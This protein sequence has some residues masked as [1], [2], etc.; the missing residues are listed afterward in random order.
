ME[1]VV[2]LF[3]TF[4]AVFC[5]I[6]FLIY[7]YKWTVGSADISTCVLFFIALYASTLTLSWFT[8]ETKE[9]QKQYYKLEY[10]YTFENNEY[11]K[12]S[13]YVKINIED[14]DISK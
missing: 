7:F 13:T 12:D 3:S 1:T 5:V 4:W 14:L 2:I 11:V 10:F 6:F 8:N 9:K